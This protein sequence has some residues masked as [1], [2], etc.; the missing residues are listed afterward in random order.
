M[1][2][3]VALRVGDPL[4]GSEEEVA[5]EN[6][7]L[8]EV[9]LVLGLAVP[10]DEGCMEGWGWDYERKRTCGLADGMED[11]GHDLTM[12]EAPVG[13]TLEVVVGS[14]EG[15]R[16]AQGGLALGLEDPGALL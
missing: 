2:Q 12:G 13:R 5:R 14:S 3:S 15:N 16:S 1:G 7:S 4:P 9:D 11:G 8:E 10:Q 6:G